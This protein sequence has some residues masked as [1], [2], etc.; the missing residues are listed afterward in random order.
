MFK[1][2]YRGK[3]FEYEGLT[4]YIEKLD[5]LRKAQRVEDLK[6]V[7]GIVDN[8]TQEEVVV[9][10]PKEEVTNEGGIV[11]GEAVLS[12][13]LETPSEEVV[14]ESETKVEELQHVDVVPKHKR[15][16]SK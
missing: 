2:T 9:S 3:V 14:L 8:S 16:K 12:D 5:A 6:N 10:Q 15:N 1:A 7:Y 13:V 4:D 11:L